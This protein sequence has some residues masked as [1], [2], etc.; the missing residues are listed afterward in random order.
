MSN[1]MNAEVKKLAEKLRDFHAP[2]LVKNVLGDWT[3]TIHS[4]AVY[5]WNSEDCLI[6]SIDEVT[7]LC[8]L[9][10]DPIHVH[11]ALVETTAWLSAS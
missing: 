6:A 5:L 3:I 9:A 2:Q 8:C 10:C 11:D 1:D 7:G 4:N